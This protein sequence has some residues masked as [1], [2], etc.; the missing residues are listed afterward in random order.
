M[1]T[2]IHV[3]SADHY[4]TTTSLIK[5]FSQ[6]VIISNGRTGKGF[7][8][9]SKV[10]DAIANN[11]FGMAR[12]GI[13]W[14]L[15]TLTNVAATLDFQLKWNE[16]SRFSASFGYYGDRDY[17][18]WS[19]ITTCR[20]NWW[21]YLELQIDYTVEYVAEGYVHWRH[22]IA[23]IVRINEEIIL[24]DTVSWLSTISTA[25]FTK[26]AF[27]TQGSTIYDDYYMTDVEFL[28]DVRIYVIYPNAPGDFSEWVSANGGENYLEVKEHIPDFNTTYIYT[29]E[30]NKISMVNLEDI[31]WN[32][33]I[34]G[35]QFNVV[36]VK[37]DTGDSAF[38]SYNKI[39]GSYE[40]NPTDIYLSYN[41]WL[42]RTVAYRKNPITENNFTISEINSL[43]AGIKRTI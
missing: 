6:P 28:G 5:W 15:L 4:D 11:T 43:Q 10:F 29:A 35:I 39:S 24:I 7:R 31:N 16:D 13:P 27:D 14:T 18:D 19:V 23:F 37:D 26:I 21:Y 32:G 40:L 42:D 36:A 25:G 34:L 30:L 17:S 1:S 8:G 3:D 22:K 12:K 33:D 20:N 9:G 41:N 2:L 38:K